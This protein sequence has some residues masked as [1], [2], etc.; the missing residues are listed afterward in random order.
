MK[1]P[2][3]VYVHVPF[4]RHRCGYCNFTLVAN[5]DDWVD[6]YLSAIEIEIL[7]VDFG[8]SEATE[9]DTLFLGGGTPTHLSPRQLERLINVVGNKFS[10]SKDFEF[11]IEANPN[12]I[13][14]E[15]V[16]LLSSLG[17]NR[18]SLGVQS[19]NKQK[20]RMLERDHDADV[21]RKAIG[22]IRDRVEDISI[23][24]IIGS[25]GETIDDWQKDLE[26][27]LSVRPTHI[28]TYSLTIEKGT[29]FWN[30]W[31]R[32]EL[33]EV[34]EDDSAN[35]YE[36]G[37]DFLKDNDFEHY[38]VSNF[39]RPG[40]RCKHNENYWLGN[41]YF[42]FGPGAARYVDGKRELNHRSTSRYLQMIQSGESPTVE[43]EPIDAEASAR[44]KL[45]FGL[46]R[47]EGID[48]SSFQ[49]ETE[50]AVFDLADREL[51]RLLR[52]KLLEFD[53]QALRLT[54]AGLLV[55]DSIWPLFL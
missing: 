6:R 17:V 45:I 22:T 2:R 31:N 23:D 42:G 40:Y 29:Q 11:S 7:G 20:L 26:S 21:V 51:N 55:S 47:I 27:A 24:L 13:S 50:F 9:I 34:S 8:D 46:R 44:E 4:C 48:T 19:F 18:F 32:G 54:R 43:S 1:L 33:T 39:S 10:Y 3:S 16:A 53:G 52:Q 15:K 12:D 30:R 28:S 25:P 41:S 38:E 14:E 49:E 36:Y 5:R 37:I 35:W